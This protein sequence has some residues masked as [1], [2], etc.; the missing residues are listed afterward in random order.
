MFCHEADTKYKY[1]LKL[2]L[3]LL[4]ES[5]SLIALIGTNICFVYSTFI[6][7]YVL[8]LKFKNDH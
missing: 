1:L 6:Q 7:I 8:K 3:C 2:M 5:Q 4:V